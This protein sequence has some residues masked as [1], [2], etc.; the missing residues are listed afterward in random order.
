MSHTLRKFQN[1]LLPFHLN[2]SRGN[3]V[4]QTQMFKVTVEVHIDLQRMLLVAACVRMR[5]NET[6]YYFSTW[7]SIPNFKSPGFSGILETSTPRSAGHARCRMSLLTKPPRL[8]AS[9]LI[10][11]RN[12]SSHRCVTGEES[13]T[14][15]ISVTLSLNSSS[16]KYHRY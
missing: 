8:M 14:S 6:D 15:K 4:F 5:K 7:N 1:N 16:K 2:K 3:N 12:C 9:S 11:S 10:R 13:S